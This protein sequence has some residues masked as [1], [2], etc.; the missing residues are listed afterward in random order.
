MKRKGKLFLILGGLFAF[1]LVAGVGLK[2][3]ENPGFCA[4]CHVMKDVY[5]SWSHSAHRSITNCNTCHTPHNLLTKIPYKA[6]AGSK[7]IFMNTFADIPT[8]FQATES[9]KKIIQSNC[10]NCHKN[11]VHN[12]NKD[13]GRYCFDCHRNTPHGR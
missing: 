8:N 12:L 4:S 9:S 5:N 1:I 13:E 3:T 10:V 7:H 11:L 2:I 6:L